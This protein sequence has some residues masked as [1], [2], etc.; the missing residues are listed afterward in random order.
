MSIGIVWARDDFRLD[1]NSALTYASKNH[2]TVSVIYIFN[3]EYFD[4]KREAQ[5]GGLVNL[6][7]ASKKI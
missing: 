2:D 6:S 3:K 5:N 4:N 7:I 1:N